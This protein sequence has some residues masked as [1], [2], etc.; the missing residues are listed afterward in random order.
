LAMIT[1]RYTGYS[2]IRIKDGFHGAR[3]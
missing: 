1:S 3:T 2:A